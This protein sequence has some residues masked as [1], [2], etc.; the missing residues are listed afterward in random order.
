MGKKKD[1]FGLED[2]LCMTPNCPYARECIRVV[3][4]K[5]LER[6]LARKNLGPAKRRSPGRVTVES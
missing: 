2:Y 6:T 3:W 1:C 5:R 4:E